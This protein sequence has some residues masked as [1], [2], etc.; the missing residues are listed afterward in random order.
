M[1]IPMAKVQDGSPPFN[2]ADTIMA[3]TPYTTVPRTV[4]LTR[5]FKKS[6][7]RDW[8]LFYPYPSLFIK[9]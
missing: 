3:I 8:L 2:I 1:A 4:S 7:L 5:L 6:L 9:N